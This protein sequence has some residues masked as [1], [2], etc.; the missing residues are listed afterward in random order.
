MGCVSAGGSTLC[1]VVLS[2]L[3][4][5]AAAVNSARAEIEPRMSFFMISL[6]RKKR[7]VGRTVVG[8]MRRRRFRFVT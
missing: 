7:P 1:V 5:Q 4:L 6:L 2:V 8:E 3:S